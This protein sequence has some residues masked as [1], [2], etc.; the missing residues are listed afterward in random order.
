MA[1]CLVLVGSALLAAGG[2]ELVAR[3]RQLD[4]MQL[5]R[6]AVDGGEPFGGS[7]E[8]AI[9]PAWRERAAPLIE[10]YLPAGFRLD[11]DGFDSRHGRCD[12]QHPGPTLLALG[13]STTIMSSDPDA[14]G[15]PMGAGDPA[16][17][18]PALLAAQ[19]PPDTQVCTVAEL[20]FHPQDH[21]RFLE[22]LGPALDPALV[23]VLLCSNDLEAQAPRVRQDDAGGSIYYVS[24]GTQAAHRALPLR[25]LFARSEAFRF[26]H[27]RA[28]LRWPEAA[29]DLPSPRFPATPAADSLRRLDEL[30]RSLALFYLPE[31]RDELPAS[32]RALEDLDVAVQVLDLPSPRP[33]L[34]YNP[35]D[36]VH[37]NRRGHR[38]VAELMLPAV[39][40]ALGL[41]APAAPDAP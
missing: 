21:A 39:R 6:V 20:G 25:P 38:A 10:G 41:A 1:A 32:G 2:V 4:R 26:L 35:Q 33:A 16:W 5:E 36:P 24:S 34:R 37:M 29:L 23:V 7:S 14:A 17:T 11:D 18:W 3:A 9:A 8:Q 12:F 27:W 40:R 28:A 15:P 19:L 31:L 22:L 13:D 30:S